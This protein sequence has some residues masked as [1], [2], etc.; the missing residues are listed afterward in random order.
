MGAAPVVALSIFKN[1]YSEKVN[2]QSPATFIS[3][4]GA[5]FN[6]FK[7]ALQDS[8]GG[9]IEIGIG[10][11]EGFKKLISVSSNTNPATYEGFI[12]NLIKSDIL[13]DE[14]IIEE[15]KTYHKA[16]GNHAPLQ[17][18]NEQIIKEEAKTNLN[19]KN[20]KIYKDGR[21]ELLNNK[22]KVEIGKKSISLEDFRSTSLRELE[23]SVSKDEAV[24]LMINN[25]VKDALPS[26]ISTES[27]NTT[28]ESLK[29]NLL[30]LL[31]NMGVK[32][33]SITNY[34]N[35]YNTRNGVDPS[36]AALLDVAK[37]VIAFK[38]GPR[39]SISRVGKRKGLLR[40]NED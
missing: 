32:I 14:K 13:S 11:E 12:N 17:I 6:S 15:G 26:G 19:R 29:M 28:E 18:I 4:K 3:D 23:K 33:T 21:I 20:F 25:A 10:A 39:R 37:Q 8:T 36:A 5:V 16:A 22:N 40:A 7:E 24:E 1:V 34:I 30:D 27:L 38:D 2:D 35:S 31:G 9:N